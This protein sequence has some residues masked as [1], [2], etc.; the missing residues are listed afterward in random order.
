MQHFP[1]DLFV[2]IGNGVDV[3][4]PGVHGLGRDGARGVC[5]VLNKSLWSILAGPTA[6]VLRTDGE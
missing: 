4:G 2:F 6:P 3:I 1:A 5:R